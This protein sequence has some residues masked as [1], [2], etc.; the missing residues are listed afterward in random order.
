MPQASYIITVLDSRGRHLD[1]FIQESPLSQLYQGKQINHS[2]YWHL[3][4][5]HKGWTADK[6]CRKV[7][8]NQTH[9]CYRVVYAAWPLS[10]VVGDRERYHTTHNL[11][12]Y[13]ASRTTNKIWS[14]CKE[15]EYY[16]IVT[17]IYTVSLKAFAQLS[18]ERGDLR[19]KIHS[20]RDSHNK[21]NSSKTSRC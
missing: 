4:H 10:T 20:S 14:H 8:P 9:N 17:T 13:I 2:R 16:M 7:S 11:T 6:K 15:R 1:K 12:E 5:K 18:T 19:Q 21:R 3:R